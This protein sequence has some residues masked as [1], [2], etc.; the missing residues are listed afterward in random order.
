MARRLSIVDTINIKVTGSSSI[1][2]IGDS[3]TLAP[4]SKA[5]AAAKEY[6]IFEGTEGGYEPFG[7]FS[8]PI[9]EVQRRCNVNMTSADEI[10]I[11]KV[12]NIHIMG[13][14]ASAMLH[15]GSTGYI[16]SESRVQHF[17]HF[18]FP[19]EQGE[20]EEEQEVESEEG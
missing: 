7:A 4:R 11:L 1:L 5:L 17:R 19:P 13:L 3:H 12:G 15:I 2:Q 6:P 8:Q 18:F 14:A 16:D 9:P 10:P 20:A